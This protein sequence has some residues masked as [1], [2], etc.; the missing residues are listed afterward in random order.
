[1]EDK[2]PMSR[3]GFH[4]MEAD[5]H[6]MRQIELKECLQNL[7]DAREKG[8]LGENAEFETA[9]Q[10]LNDLHMRMS[11]LGN[12]LMNA[13]IIDSI[14]D[15]GTVQLLTYV[16]FKQVKSG[17]VVDFKIVPECDIDI[18]AK[19][20]SHNSPIGKALMNKRVGDIVTAETPNGK[21]EL[22]ILKI[23]LS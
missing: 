19:K 12:I 17:L 22:E 15:D 11:K 3:D 23:Y 2:I 8:D 5:L 21:I 20:I 14:V 18:K 4:K 13:K 1:M 10:A 6:Q 16:K 9:K 7:N